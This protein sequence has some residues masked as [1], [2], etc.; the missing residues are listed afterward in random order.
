MAATVNTVE[1]VQNKV[2]PYRFEPVAEQPEHHVGVAA[3]L[4]DLNRLVR[5]D[6]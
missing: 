2:V 3:G 4:A 6:C 1:S 5:N